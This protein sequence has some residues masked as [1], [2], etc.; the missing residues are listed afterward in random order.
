MRRNKDVPEYDSPID[1]HILEGME[2]GNPLSRKNLKKESKR[3]R[4]AHK[5]K[6][7]IEKGGGVGVGQMEVDHDDDE[8][9]FTFKA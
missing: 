7:G 4:K 5:V 2:K 6:M 8:F 3:V 9:R 1:R